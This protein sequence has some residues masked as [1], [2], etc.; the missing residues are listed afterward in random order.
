MAKLL[1]VTFGFSSPGVSQ[2]A[3]TRTERFFHALRK[4]TRE[5]MR[6]QA[7][8]QELRDAAHENL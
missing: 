6:A 2:S 1:H 7:S 5:K 4:T 3:T 8:W